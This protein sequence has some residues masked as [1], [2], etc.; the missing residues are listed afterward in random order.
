MP[1]EGGEDRTKASLDELSDLADSEDL[2]GPADDGGG[3]QGEDP[4]VVEM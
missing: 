4:D 2:E 1:E 3:G